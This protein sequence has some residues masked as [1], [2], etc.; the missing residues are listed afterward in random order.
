[1]TALKCDVV[2]VGGGLA[3]LASAY[4]L[5]RKGVDVIVVERGE[6]PGSKNVFGGTLYT[7]LWQKFLPELTPKIPY[8]REVSR[9]LYYMVIDQT[10]TA[11]DYHRDIDPLTPPEGVTILRSSFDRWLAD[12]AEAVGAHIITSA[13]TRKILWEDG[14]AAGVH[15][16]PGGWIHSKVVILAEGVNGFLTQAAGLG[17]KFRTDQISLGIKQTLRVGE[18]T[19]D[20]RFQVW[21][22][23]GAACFFVGSPLGRRPGGG[24]LYTNR[25][26]LSLGLVVPLN[27]ISSSTTRAPD[28]LAA[29]QDTY[30]I[31]DLIRGATPVEYAAHLIP[32]AGLEM[33]PQLVG[34]RILVAGDAAGFLV[35][36]GFRIRGAD[37]AVA[38]GLAAAEVS[39]SALENGGVEQ[40]A[41]NSYPSALEAFGVSQEMKR[42]RRMPEILKNQRWYKAYPEATRDLL[43]NLTTVGTES[44]SGF[45]SVVRQIVRNRIGWLNMI[46]DLKKILRR[47]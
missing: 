39:A 3:G 23:R 28:L 45:G 8:E 44:G 17:Q 46:K 42:Y 31:C 25:D 14:R 26:T 40:N 2:V 30:P 1:M 24:F 15:I 22:G 27:E 18:D 29:F 33:Q 21:G 7:A 20:E 4:S 13:T 47:A 37:L 5:A 10:Y 19:I 34:P 35:N 11:L 16:E 36:A 43:E 32:S 9:H 12:Q 41:L 38:S 6:F